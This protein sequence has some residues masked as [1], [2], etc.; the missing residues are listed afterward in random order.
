MYLNTNETFKVQSYILLNFKDLFTLFFDARLVTCENLGYDCGFY[1]IISNK[2][3]AAA[4][5]ISGKS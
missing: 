1:F 5:I 2:E 4:I 3:L